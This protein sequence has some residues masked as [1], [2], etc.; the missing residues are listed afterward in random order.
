VPLSFDSAPPSHADL[1]SLEDCRTG[2]LQALE[3]VLFQLR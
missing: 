1:P 3:L 2:N